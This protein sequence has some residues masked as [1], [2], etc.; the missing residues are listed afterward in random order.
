MKLKIDINDGDDLTFLR[1]LRD[2]TAVV[3]DQAPDAGVRAMAARV[4]QALE[5]VL[6]KSTDRRSDG[7]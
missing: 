6:G 7:G 5:S 2:L 4:Y 3:R 1:A